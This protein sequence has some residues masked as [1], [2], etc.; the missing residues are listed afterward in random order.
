MRKILVVLVMAVLSA[1]GFASVA[2]ATGADKDIICHRDHLS[3]TPPLLS[4]IEVAH[5]AVPAHLAHGDTEGRCFHPAETVTI[6]VPG[7]T[8]TVTVEKEVP[9]P[10]VTVEVPGPVVEKQVIVPQYVNVPV[11]SDRII[12]VPVVKTVIKR[13]TKVKNVPVYIRD[14]CIPGPKPMP[15]PDKPPV[16]PR[17]VPYTP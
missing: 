10:T 1:A 2:V 15:K 13:V 3:I 7:P 8:H 14:R 6:E 11:Y 9:G 5:D 16:R 17:E 4:E 12:E